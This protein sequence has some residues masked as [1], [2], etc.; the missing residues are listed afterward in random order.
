MQLYVPHG[1]LD[2]Y[3]GG[4]EKPGSRCSWGGVRSQFDKAEERCMCIEEAG[5]WPC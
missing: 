2:I 4:K 3:K 5:E 1:G